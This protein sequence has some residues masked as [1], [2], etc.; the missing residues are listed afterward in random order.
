[1]TRLVRMYYRDIMIWYQKRDHRRIGKR[2]ALFLLSGFLLAMTAS[3]ALLPQEPVYERAPIVAA[4]TTKPYKYATIQRGDI[5]IR[6]NIRFEYEPTQEAAL[7]FSVGGLL[8]EDVYVN[9]GSQVTEGQIL[10]ALESGDID[11]Q[12]SSKDAAIS[13]SELDIEQTKERQ[14][15]ERKTVVTDL[16]Y[17]GADAA[18]RQKQLQE[19]DENHANALKMMDDNLYILKLERE[20]LMSRLN[21]RRI[22]AP[23]DATVSYVR[24]IQEGG[25]STSG[26]TL[27]RV[28]V[29]ESSMFIGRTAIP[30]YFPVGGEIIL[31]VGDDEMPVEVVETVAATDGQ[32]DLFQVYLKL[33]ADNIVLETGTRGNADILIDASRDTLLMDAD[34]LHFAEEK[35]FVYVESDDGLP[36]VRYIEVGLMTKDLVEVISGLEEGERVILE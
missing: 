10:A 13:R 20:Q 6:E 1:M 28:V 27:I 5:E 12:I 22:I 36:E 3:C 33:V 24:G 32:L 11:E 2:I 29:S 9:Q 31:T 21:E 14:A 34:G 25:R 18:E 7:A 17:N 19:L 16:Q 30:E 35:P 4:Y 15:L 8:F 26:E 23:F